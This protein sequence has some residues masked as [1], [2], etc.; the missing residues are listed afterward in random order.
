MISTFAGAI[1]YLKK[2]KIYL[3]IS[4]Y[5]IFL[6]IPA[7]RLPLF[8]T[9]DA[10]YAEISR[11]MLA[12]GNFIEPYLN[13]I[14]HFHKPPLAYWINAF[15][16][17]LFGVNGFGA[18]FFGAVA[19]VIILLS[20]RRTAYILSNDVKIADTAL[21][22]LASSFLFIIVSHVVSTDIYLVMFT[23]LTLHILFEQMY[24]KATIFN[25]FLV[26]LL[27]GLG[28]LTKGPI[29]FLFT[30]LPFS[31]SKIFD[32]GHRKV[33]NPVDI[34]VIAAVFL[35]VAS[36]WYLYVTRINDSLLHYFF[37]HQV[38]DRV[39]TNKFS[40]SKPFYFFFVIF[41][42]TFLP[43]SFFMIRNRKFIDRIK[44]G[45]TMYL[46]I[47]LPF[48][49]FQLSTSKLGT[50]IL[51]FYPITSI[52]AAVDIESP[53]LK[54]IAGIS[55]ILMGITVGTLPFIVDY[56]RPYLYLLLPFGLLYVVFSIFIYRKLFSGPDFI[57]AFTGLIIIWAMFLYAF[58]PLAGPYIKG[59]RVIAQDIKKY[60]PANKYDLLI[61]RSF[62][63]SLSFY[64]NDIKTTA[65]GKERET[66]FQYPDEYKPYLIDDIAGF[67]KYLL[68]K[69]EFLVFVRKKH[70][71]N[72]LDLSGCECRDISFRGKDHYIMHCI[73]PD[74][75]KASL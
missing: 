10:R 26:G 67:K 24:E 20:T 61:Y 34:V 48:I 50:Y 35:A 18:R 5:F 36:P 44:P 74:I 38:V 27:T 21:Y 16:L 55:L 7:Y 57:H 65:F 25:A 49:V 47:L 52:I 51:P 15:G 69:K 68:S 56:A 43:W 60:D 30:L 40:R 6:L 33:F 17:Y 63:P 19:A 59:Y 72:F 28:F 29:I 9:T 31:V 66:R 45:R 8:E 41:F 11:E 53:T 42:G 64:L 39:A 13:G 58:I 75:S 70:K 1:E 2:N 73:V 32:P 22:I 46:Y 54:R 23:I 37:N 14:K 62:I 71:K 4:F 3:F 12:G